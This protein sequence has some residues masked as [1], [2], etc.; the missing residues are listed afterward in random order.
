METITEMTGITAVHM[1][2]MLLGGFII[3]MM[4]GIGEDQVTI[5]VGI[6]YPAFMSFLALETK[7]TDDDKQWLTY[8]IVF[9]AFNIVDHFA[10][11][12]TDF[13][14][15]YLFFKVLFLV[16]L[17]HPMTQGA[18]MIYNT[19]ILPNVEKYESKLVEAENK[20]EEAVEKAKL[21]AGNVADDIQERW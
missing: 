9:G 6:L 16:Y 21:V 12:I 2:N 15:F 11:V 8:W 20:I 10:D 18:L 19:L 7:Q 3:C 17:M 1:K 14:P 5:A 13:I 4:L